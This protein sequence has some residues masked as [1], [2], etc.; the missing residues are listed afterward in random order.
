MLKGNIDISKLLSIPQLSFS[1][2]SH[3]KTKF[4]FC[5]NKTGRIELYI[6]NINTREVTQITHGELPKVMR[7]GYLWA[8]NNRDIIL[9]IDLDGN[10]QNDTFLF[11]TE[12]S[13]MTRLS[14]TPKAQEYV[15]DISPDGEWVSYNSNVYGQQNVFIMKLDG[16]DITQITATDN[17]SEGGKFSPDMKYLVFSSYDKGKDMNQTVYLY[18]LSHKEVEEL[19]GIHLGA[20]DWIGVNWSDDG[21][22][23]FYTNEIKNEM[24]AGLYNIETKKIKYFGKKLEGE[25]SPV[26]MTQDNKWLICIAS[27]E[28]SDFVVRFNTVS[29]EMEEFDLPR[30]WITG[31]H[32]INDE[33]IILYINTPNYPGKYILFNFETK[34]FENLF[35]VELN[36]IDPSLFVNADHIWYESIDGT[37]IPGILY[38]PRNFDSRNTYPAIIEPHGG[39]TAQ[40]YLYFNV[41]A[42]YFTDLG[43]IYFQPNVRGSTGYGI[44]FRDACIKDWGGKDH[45]DWIAAHKYLVNYVSADPNAIGLYGGSY[46][47]YA[48]L[49]CMTNSPD[50][51]RFGI[52][53][54]PVSDLHNLYEHSMDHYKHY[55]RQQMGDPIKD[56]ELWIERSP[57]THAKNLKKPLLLLHGKNDARCHVSESLNF[58][59]E[60][61][62]HGFKEEKDFEI[63]IF[64]DIGHGGYSDINFRIR[65]IRIVTEFISNALSK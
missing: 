49:W 47:G 64:D 44:E 53:D 10:E 8:R 35:F 58:A 57:I 18:H 4:A 16:S 1:N 38:K 56:K 27:R 59:K 26:A 41:Y 46:G 54:I 40:S 62:K 45:E 31:K 32:L 61:E 6:M 9:N 60:L 7:W 52:A 12:T 34:K 15:I 65:T 14:N 23:L 30:G 39:P 55:F 43:F 3:D 11:N 37:K 19:P 13:K 42:Q 24:C 22:F 28:S 36:D 21:K 63:V 48:T 50:F 2:L 5:Y 29:G 17:P 33:T 25:I 51:W 20:F